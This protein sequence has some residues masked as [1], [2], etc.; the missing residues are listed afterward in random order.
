MKGLSKTILLFFVGASLLGCQKEAS[1]ESVTSPIAT[2]KP[3]PSP[4]V[5]P[6]VTDLERIKPGMPAP[7]FALTNHDGVTHRLSEFKGKK[8]VVLVFYRGYFC[9]SCVGQLVI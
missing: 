4:T 3:E 1:L 2:P 7:D 9:G 6:R 5:D 8:T